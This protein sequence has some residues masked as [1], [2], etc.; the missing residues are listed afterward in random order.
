MAKTDNEKTPEG[1]A[2]PK[3][4]QEPR[5][6]YMLFG[7][8]EDPEVNRRVQDFVKDIENGTIPMLEVGERD[9]RKVLPK[10]AAGEI[11]AFIA[12]KVK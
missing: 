8:H 1:E 9:A 12:F 11:S 7:R 10:M 5:G 3:R 2:K 4:V 6:A